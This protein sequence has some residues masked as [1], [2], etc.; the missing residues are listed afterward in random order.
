MG[1]A[2]CAEPVGLTESVSQALQGEHSL[3]FT[4]E[5]SEIQSLSNLTR[6]IQLKH[7]NDVNIS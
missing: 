3:L 2:V 6:I 5:D 7:N 1:P 4:E